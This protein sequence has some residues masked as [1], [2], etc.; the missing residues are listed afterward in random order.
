M[1][2]SNSMQS[3]PPAGIVLGV[4]KGPWPVMILGRWAIRASFNGY[5]AV[6][7]V[8]Y[9]LVLDLRERAVDGRFASQSAEHLD[10]NAQGLNLWNSRLNHLM[11]HLD[12]HFI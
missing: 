12:S 8:G 7:A 3:S 10:R 5:A 6:S 2:S 9:D 11:I 1:L 4:S